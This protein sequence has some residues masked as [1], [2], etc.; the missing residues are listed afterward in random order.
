MNIVQHCHE[1]IT[2]LILLTYVNIYT[3]FS[4]ACSEVEWS[5]GT[6]L[7]LGGRGPGFKW[8]GHIRAPRFDPLFAVYY[9]QCYCCIFQRFCDASTL[10]RQSCKVDRDSSRLDQNSDLLGGKNTVVRSK[11]CLWL[12]RWLL[13]KRRERQSEKILT[14]GTTNIHVKVPPSSSEVVSDLRVCQRVGAPIHESSRPLGRAE[15]LLGR[16]LL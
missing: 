8:Y 5:S 16:G 6:I 12:S 1:C 2:R 3:P 11:L 14:T 13:Q 4:R 7:P 10:S 15:R 9:L